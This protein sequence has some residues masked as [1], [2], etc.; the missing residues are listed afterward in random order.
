M[1]NLFTYVRDQGSATS[2]SNYLDFCGIFA[3][4]NTS[5]IIAAILDV[6]RFVKVL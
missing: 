6:F 5:I 2:R 4:Y 3:L 1:K